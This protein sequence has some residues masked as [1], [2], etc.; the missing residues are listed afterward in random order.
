MNLLCAVFLIPV[1]SASLFH[2]W[3]YTSAADDAVDKDSSSSATPPASDAGAA[4]AN[5][6]SRQSEIWDPASDADGEGFAVSEAIADAR[7]RAL[8]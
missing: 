8:S 5:G 6:I 7:R 2:E 1:Q 4:A 3:L